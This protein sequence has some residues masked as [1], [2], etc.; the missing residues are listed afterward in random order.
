[1]GIAVEIPVLLDWF[2]PLTEDQ[3]FANSM[4]MLNG[5]PMPHPDPNL[6]S[7]RLER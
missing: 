4:A 2:P 6:I 3:Q 1:M 5:L 7:I